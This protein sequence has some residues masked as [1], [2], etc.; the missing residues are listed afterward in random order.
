MSTISGK[1]QKEY[2][3]SQFAH[4]LFQQTG[5]KLSVAIASLVHR[6]HVRDAILKKDFSIKQTSSGID[7]EY[8][9]PHELRLMDLRRYGR[10][11]K[12]NYVSVYN[13]PLMGFIY[14]YLYKQLIWGYSRFI[15]EAV[16]QSLTDAG[17]N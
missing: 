3:S 15:N 14:G 16:N 10:T 1:Y 13:K 7:F 17:F 5:T 8:R 6:V 11:R 4:T 2:L 9:V 12:K